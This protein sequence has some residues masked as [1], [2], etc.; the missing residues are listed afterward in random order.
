MI[1]IH[2]FHVPNNRVFVEE[3]EFGEKKTSS[4][5]I[6]SMDD[7]G[8][9]SG[10]RPRWGK[11]FA[12]GENIKDLNVGDYVLLDHG[13]WTRTIEIMDNNIKKEINMIDYPK[14]VLLVST[15]RPSEIDNKVER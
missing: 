1:N 13:K 4:G 6:V 7:N 2:N 8:K 5:I 3:L 14:A 11:V 15:Q 9:I 10:V 12:V